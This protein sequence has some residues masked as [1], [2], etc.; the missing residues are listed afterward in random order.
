MI[1]GTSTTAG[2]APA[3]PPCLSQQRTC[4][5]LFREMQLRNSTGCT[6]WTTTPLLHNNGQDDNIV[7]ELDEPTSTTCTTGTSTTS[8]SKNSQPRPAATATLPP[9]HQPPPPLT[10]SAGASTPEPELDPAGSTFA[11]LRWSQW[12]GSLI[13]QPWCRARALDGCMLTKHRWLVGW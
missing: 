6:V 1:T 9:P 8:T 3:A 7:Q 4:H 11:L 12:A 13:R 10:F 5:H 2:P